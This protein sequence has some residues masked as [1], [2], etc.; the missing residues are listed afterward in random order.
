MT[1][2]AYTVAF[3]GENGA[4]S[5]Q[6]TYALLGREGIQAVGYQSF[7]DAFAAISDG[8]VH[9]LLVPIENTLGGTIHANCDLQLQHNLFIIAEHNL[10]I[11]HCLMALPGSKK[12]HL[13]K[14]I[15]H[16]Q[17]LAQCNSYLKS[18]ELVGEAA[19]DT[20]G[21]AKLISEGKLK[22]VG[23]ICSELA[24]EH[25]GLEILEKGQG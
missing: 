1:S 18:N 13:Q 12:A 9:L 21:S 23:A 4:Y 15:S 3:Q 22:G 8:K 7:D 16:P 2:T 24:A 19:Y 10:R 6:A 25:F 17:A 5:E 14:V 11:R 20:A